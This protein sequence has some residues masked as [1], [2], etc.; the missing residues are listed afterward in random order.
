MLLAALGQ[1]S[2]AE[3]RS[4]GVPARAPVRLQIDDPRRNTLAR[5]R[6]SAS[7]DRHSDLDNDSSGSNST[8]APTSTSSGPT[9]KVRRW[10]G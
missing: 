10:I 3:A 6:C 5:T 1:G 9:C 7:A 4:T 2:G 8:L